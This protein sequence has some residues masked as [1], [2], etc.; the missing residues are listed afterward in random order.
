MLKF[1]KKKGQKGFTLIELMIVVAIIGILAAIAIPQFM[2][3]RARGY[4][5]TT[6]ADAR[7]AYT[8]TQAYMADNPGATP[9]AVTTVG[10]GDLSSTLYP[11]MRVS[12]GVT[13]AIDD[14]GQVTGTY[15]GD[16]SHVTGSVIY[17]PTGGVTDDLKVQ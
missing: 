9:P 5:A 1:F 2:L 17:A 10:P 13:I 16:T 8:G 11:G 7:N 6:R 4:V 15:S 3:Y 14:T 12:N